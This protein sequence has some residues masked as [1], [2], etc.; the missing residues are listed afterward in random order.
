MNDGPMFDKHDVYQ[1][2]GFS[3]VSGGVY[4]YSTLALA[5]LWTASGLLLFTISLISELNSE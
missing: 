1:L 4:L 2:L 5:V 3:L